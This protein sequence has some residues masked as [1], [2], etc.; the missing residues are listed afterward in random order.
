MLTDVQVGVVVGNHCSV[1][2]FSTSGLRRKGGA[3]VYP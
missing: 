3:L 2:T 1:G